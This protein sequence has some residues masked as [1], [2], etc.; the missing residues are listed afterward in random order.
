MG[1]NKLWRIKRIVILPIKQYGDDLHFDSGNVL[2]AAICFQVSV[3]TGDEQT[4]NRRGLGL[5]RQPQPTKLHYY[6]L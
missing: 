1:L 5:Q 2:L 4:Q 6:A 3:H